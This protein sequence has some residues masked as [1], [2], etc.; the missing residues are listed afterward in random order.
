MT[1][2]RTSGEGTPQLQF[3]TSV[4][5][6]SSVLTGSA[7]A[8]KRAPELGRRSAWGRLVQT[9]LVTGA[10]LF[11]GF[12]IVGASI[13]RLDRTKI[14]FA[15]K[16]QPDVVV[17]DSSLLPRGQLSWLAIVL[18]TVGLSSATM[19]WRTRQLHRAIE[20]GRHDLAAAREEAERARQQA[21]HAKC[22]K[23]Q[24]LSNMNHELRTPLNG[25]LGM[26]QIMQMHDLSPGQRERLDTLY[27]SG[28][29]L[30]G[31][32]SSI[33]DAT[34]LERDLVQLGNESFDL[35]LLVEE[36]CA[37][38]EAAAASKGIKLQYTIAQ[39][40]CHFR[41]DALRLRQVLSNLIG[42]AI[43]FTDSGVV[44]VWVGPVEG[45]VCFAVADT[46]PGISRSEQAQIFERFS[47]VDETASRG[48]EGLGLGLALC[49]ET[50]ALMG[51]SIVVESEPG[52]GA[53]FAFTVPLQREFFAPGFSTL[54]GSQ[55]QC[56]M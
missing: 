1:V 35:E 41:G 37:G 54:S 32:L 53:A 50:A 48:F 4:S 26:A 3:P 45:K 51:G 12:G 29:V 15:F 47:Q 19:V 28:M 55:Q 40:G 25:V 27:R 16:T 18:A 14:E 36:T 42:N 8:Q 49:R 2:R 38:F 33:L 44:T 13:A 46:G 31:H 10:I 21:D 7:Q 43:K 39:F 24:F 22:A 6:D 34:L 30:L 23:N 9:L 52:R 56:M 11:G 20:A 5:T 17:A